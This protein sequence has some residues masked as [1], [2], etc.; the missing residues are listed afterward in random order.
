MCNPVRGNIEITYA[1]ERSA[2]ISQKSFWKP[3]QWLHKFCQEKMENLAVRLT[4]DKIFF[5]IGVFAQNAAIIDNV[6]K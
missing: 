5:H 3:W 2:R 1:A 6:K 4:D